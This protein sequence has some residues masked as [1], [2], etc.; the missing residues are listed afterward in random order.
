MQLPVGSSTK[1]QLPED[2][3]DVSDSRRGWATVSAHGSVETTMA[4]NSGEIKGG[5]GGGGRG[6]EG[7][8]QKEQER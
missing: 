2:D 6:G 4:G 1:V 7:G 5:G 3:D 8:R